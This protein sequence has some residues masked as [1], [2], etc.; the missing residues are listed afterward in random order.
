MFFLLG[1]RYP[2]VTFAIG[3]ALLIAGVVVGHVMVE[4]I[5]CLGLVIGGYRC[6]RQFR[7]RGMIGGSGS[8]GSLR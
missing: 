2:W 5:G 4:V 7:R 6:V 3:L 1:W 8:R